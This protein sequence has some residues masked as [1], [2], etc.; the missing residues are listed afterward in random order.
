MEKNN[1][2]YKSLEDGEKGTGSLG[3]DRTREGA[4]QCVTWELRGSRTL[5]D[6]MYG[7]ATFTESL[8]KKYIYILLKYSFF[9]VLY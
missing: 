9:T 7:V 2:D 4:V 8:H 6:I 5:G 3:L 1:M